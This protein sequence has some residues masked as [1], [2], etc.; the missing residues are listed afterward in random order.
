MLALVRAARRPRSGRRPLRRWL[1]LVVWLCT[2][3]P[4]RAQA[5]ASVDGWRQTPALHVGT[6]ALGAMGGLLAHESAHLSMNFALGNTP[7]FRPIRGLFGAPF[8]AI[9][10]DIS[11]QGA[12]CEGA[13]GQRFAAGVRGRAWIASAGFVMQWATSE[14]I[15]SDMP[16][17]LYRNEP[18]LQE[19]LALNVTLALAYAITCASGIES[20]F[21]DASGLATHGH[22]PRSATAALVATPALVDA[23]RA[24]WP[25]RPWIKWAARASKLVFVGL[26][27]WR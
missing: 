9:S 1:S 7:R 2:L 14:M 19:W 27:A 20:D 4:A 11:C 13:D 10:P 8:V 24:V 16:D 6:L 3:A 5:A 22:M 21:G 26:V 18:F 17:V 15:L 12:K 25:E 23:A